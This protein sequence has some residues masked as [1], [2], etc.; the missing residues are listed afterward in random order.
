MPYCRHAVTV[1]SSQ[2]EGKPAYFD[3]FAGRAG[4][5]PAQGG[6]PAEQFLV[7][8]SCGMTFEP[9]GPTGPTQ[10]QRKR[11]EWHDRRCTTHD[12]QFAVLMTQRR[13]DCLQ[14]LPDM[15]AFDIRPANL[16]E[17]L[18]SVRAALDLGSRIVL[19]S[20]DG[21][22]DGFDWP[23][24]DPD[25]A[26]A[27]LRLAVLYEEVPGGAG[28]LRQFAERLGEVA[29]AIVPVLDGCACEKSCC[30]CLR[31]YGNQQDP[32]PR[33]AR[34]RRLPPPLRRN[35]ACSGNPCPRLLRRVRRTAPLAHRAAPCRRPHKRRSPPRHRPA[36]LGRPRLRRRQPPPRHRRRLRLA[37]PEGRRLLRRVGKPPHPRTPGLRQGKTRRTPRRRVEGS[38]LLG[39][40]DR[41]RRGRMRTR[42]HR[43]PG[44]A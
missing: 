43:R 10:A 12:Q 13:G 35:P 23:R 28:F 26:D 5:E 16:Q 27:M 2:A 25:S 40:P 9:P 36:L 42:D 32:P 1:R 41:P 6:D 3:G 7:S 44:S 38:V 39:R 29:A 4:A 8:T 37:R 33:P 11:D 20:G 18:A 31:S 21:E 19:Q 30:A 15:E 34:R 17:Y 24:P 22:V 14:L